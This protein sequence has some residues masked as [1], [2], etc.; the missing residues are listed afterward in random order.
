MALSFVPTDDDT[1]IDPEL[2]KWAS[3][4]QLKA[5]QLVA[6]NGGNVRVAEKAL[7]LANDVLGH[8]IRRL[9]KLA[10]SKGFSPPHGL[11]NPVPDPF[12]V[13]KVSTLR[14]RDGEITAQWVQ[15]K[16]EA[17]E[18]RAAM[19]AAIA[20]AMKGLPVLPPSS[21]PHATL[22]DLLNVHVFTDYHVGMRA[23]SEE[24][25]AHW[26]IETAERLI[27]RAFRFMLDNSPNAAVGFIAQ[28]GDFAHFDGLRPVTPTSGHIMDASGHYAEIV[29]AIIRIMLAMIAMALAKYGKVV[30]LMAE[31]NHDIASSVWM[32]ELLKAMFAN[33]PRIEIVDS[34]TPFYAYE[35]GQTMIA[36]HHG[37]AKRLPDMPKMFANLFSAM[38]GRTT[39]RYGKAG[40]Y[41]HEIKVG[42]DSGMVVTQ[43]PTLAP[44]DSH[45]ARHGYGSNRQTSVETYSARFGKV[46]ELVVT[47]EMLED[48]PLAA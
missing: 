1:P 4:A 21:P 25:G 43:Y 13:T 14:N 36:V 17:E 46:S 37:H 19:F 2:A 7:G 33:E 41:H 10:A 30:V 47:P 26:D 44:N 39:K 22:S 5:L 8:P 42:E 32:R 45:S 23:W 27:L 35:W 24:G 11:T 12:T 40:H 20:E 3:P 28:L 29:R 48:V 34:A 31:G 16:P 9:R 18:Q 38:W 6:E 15:A